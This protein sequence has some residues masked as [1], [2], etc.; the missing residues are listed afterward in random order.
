MATMGRLLRIAAVAAITILAT[1][2][3][4]P[5]YT[6]RT[7]A[8]EPTLLLGDQVLAPGGEP[9]S[10]LRRGD[11]IAFHFPPDPSAILIKRLMGLPG[12]HL[13]IINGVLV[14]NSRRIS[15]PY[16]EHLDGASASL[17]FSNFPSFADGNPSVTPDA[18]KMLEH[19][20][21]SGELVVPDDG[22]F[23][24]GDNRDQSYDSRSWGTVA[25]SQVVG[26]VRE[27]LSSED[28]NTKTSR[29]DRVHLS[30]QRGNLK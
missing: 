24:L 28:P 26:L 22:F 15:E 30:V 6:V 12:D 9:I 1:N 25:T 3:D 20:P 8:M 4:G 16:V 29:P 23:V 2:A 13:R 17:F 7:S 18:R 14:V 10:D 21:R 5:V 19:Y 27:I 11:V